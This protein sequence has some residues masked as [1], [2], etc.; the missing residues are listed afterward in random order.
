MDIYIGTSVTPWLEDV[1]Y[2][3]ATVYLSRGTGT[4]VLTVRQADADPSTDPGI[5]SDPIDLAAG[6][7][8]TILVTG[9][10]SL[11]QGSS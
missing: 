1:D 10:V 6:A 8:L 3:M 5:Q 7:S 2:G 4:V 11:W 9:Q